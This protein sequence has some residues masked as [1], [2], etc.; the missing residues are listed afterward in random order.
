M[1]MQKSGIF[2]KNN[3]KIDISEIEN[4]IKLETTVIIQ[5]NI[6]VFHIANLIWNIVC[7]KK[8]LKFFIMDQTMIIILS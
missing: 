6:E 8:F 5:E 2:V 3:L 7:L 4:M 1:K